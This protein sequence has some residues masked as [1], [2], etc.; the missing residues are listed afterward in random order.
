MIWIAHLKVSIFVNLSPSDT[1]NLTNRCYVYVRIVKNEKIHAA[2]HTDAFLP[3]GI[4]KVVL[5]HCKKQDRYYHRHMKIV[6]SK[7][8]YKY[9]N[10]T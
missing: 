5:W 4:I 3:Q 10:R 9:N 1:T 7:C 2:T 6:I 8:T